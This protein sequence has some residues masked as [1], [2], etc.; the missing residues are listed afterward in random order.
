MRDLIPLSQ[1]P[2]VWLLVSKTLQGANYDKSEEGPL[3]GLDAALT[4]LKN[5]YLMQDESWVEVR[6]RIT[7]GLI[8]DTADYGNTS[9]SMGAA[10]MK[11]ECEKVGFLN[12][13]TG[14]VKYQFYSREN[15]CL[16]LVSEYKPKGGAN[17][18]N[19]KIGGYNPKDLETSEA[20][21]AALARELCDSKLPWKGQ[22]DVPVYVFITG[23]IRQYWEEAKE[24][25]KVKE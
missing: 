14:G 7:I 20:T 11:S 16:R 2:N 19:L 9:V 13:G 12:C 1:I 3:H 10:A 22:D 15:G 18:N 8:K 17:F 21:K 24:E 23:T 6:D 4:L 25:E 5:L